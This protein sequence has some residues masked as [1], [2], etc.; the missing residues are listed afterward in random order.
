MRKEEDLIRNRIGP[1]LKRFDLTEF[2]AAADEQNSE[3]AYGI[4]D[5]LSD[6]FGG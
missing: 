4:A 3:R 2:L 1:S 5:E 6:K